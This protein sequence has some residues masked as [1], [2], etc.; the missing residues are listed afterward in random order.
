MKTTTF[1]IS[2]EID[3]EA[4]TPLEAAK[5]AQKWLRKDDWQ[6]YVQND[7]TKEIFSVDLCEEDEDAVISIYEYFP[8]ITVE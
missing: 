7:E 6:F 2:W 4:N 8:Q 5:I 1:K 3:M